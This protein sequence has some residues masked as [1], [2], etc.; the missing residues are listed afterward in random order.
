M[1]LDLPLLIVSGFYAFVI[2][3]RSLR[4]TPRAYDWA[5]VGA[6]VMVTAGVTRLASPS[7]AG[8][9]SF[10]VCFVFGL[11]PLLATRFAMTASA[12]LMPNAAWALLFLSYVLHP[13]KM[14]RQHAERF[15]AAALEHRGDVAGTVAVL[16]RLAAR[17]PSGALETL[18][19]RLTRARV[20][21][22]WDEIAAEIDALRD[23]DIRKHP[24]LF[25][26]VRLDL[27][28]GRRSVAFAR[29]MRMW[30]LLQPAALASVRHLTALCLFAFAGQ[31]DRVEM[32]LQSHL[33]SFGRGLAALW[34]AT[35]TAA[36]ESGVPEASRLA[37]LR[38]L[39]S[40]PDP[41]IASTAKVRLRNAEM[42][43]PLSERDLA[44]LTR[45]AAE[46]RAEARLRFGA[47][48]RSVPAA[49]LAIAGLLA[50]VFMVE[51]ARGGSE[52]ERVLYDLGALSAAR[53]VDHHELYRL[54]MFMVL[55]YGVVH[56]AFN[57]LALF[58]L[59]PFV[60]RSLG[61]ARF[62]VVYVLAGLT[63]GVL[64]VV[65]HVWFSPSYDLLVGASGS[66]MGMVGARIAILLAAHRTEPIGSAR[67]PLLLTLLL[68]VLQ[69]L[70]DMLIPNVSMF[71]HLTGAIAGFVFTTLLTI[72][73]RRGPSV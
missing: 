8:A 32:M 43:G 20:L 49:T 24:I 19:E 47:E 50:S 33:S 2:F 69:T 28:L 68:V 17:A 34:R 23:E 42:D 56:L 40:D 46:M 12:R 70:S 48:R 5:I 35:A 38:A 37:G 3:V 52:N 65:G 51:V 25:S 29:T 31:L 66:I 26:T 62:V 53:V 58:A 14:M 71:A 10:A 13:T 73:R 67:G 72:G 30:P 4:S 18:W 61:V 16:D 60:E 57:V 44:F 54:G 39:A 55:H 59:A 15:R 6:L 63:G 11:V 36:P 64:T 1:D 9:V 27:D 41:I 21:G 7:H 45:I 22:K